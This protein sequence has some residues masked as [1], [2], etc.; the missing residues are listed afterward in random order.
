MLS[1]IALGGVETSNVSV[2]SISE[3]IIHKVGDVSV[4]LLVLLHPPSWYELTY[5]HMGLGVVGHCWLH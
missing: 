2:M 4:G 3:L 1:D 5:H